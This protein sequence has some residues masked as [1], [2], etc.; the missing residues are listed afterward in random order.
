MRKNM[1]LRLAVVIVAFGFAGNLMAQQAG[2]TDP[3]TGPLGEAPD[4]A[5]NPIVFSVDEGSIGRPNAATTWDAN[6]LVKAGIIPSAHFFMS[7]STG[8]PPAGSHIML[9][10]PWQI[11]LLAN[12]HPS[13]PVTNDDNIDA[14]SLGND[15]FSG[16]G[17]KIGGD[18]LGEDV[19]FSERV[20]YHQNGQ[21]IIQGGNPLTVQF[22]V[23]RV[24]A[25][26]LG[27]AVN[28]NYNSRL[29]P[30][31]SVYQTTWNGYS[32]GTNSELYSPTVLA[33]TEQDDL[34]SMENYVIDDDGSIPDPADCP[35]PHE[36]MFDG[37]HIFFSV[38]RDTRGGVQSAVNVQATLGHAAG[39]IFVSVQPVTGGPSTNL[40]LIS[41]TQLGLSKTG[42]QSL[43][44]D[45]D[46]MV[47]NLLINEADLE[48][49]IRQGLL[50]LEQGV[51]LGMTEPLLDAG[52]ALVMF[53]V[54]EGSIG[55]MNTA[56]D[57]E[58]RI[59]NSEESGDLFFSDLS[60]MNWL[61]LEAT[62]LGLLESDELNALDTTIP[63]PA[64]MLLVGS[65]LLG[66]VGIVRRRRM[67]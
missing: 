43:E 25:G 24:A 63:E 3:H 50:N 52:D 20:N 18:W 38:D 10:T 26:V 14:M 40:L 21:P 51:G 23:N 28:N 33:L 53:S 1:I 49:L 56:V 42:V 61:S 8:T 48:E 66:L 57:Y 60:G 47:L 67:H 37:P 15:Y 32:V 30:A 35:G 41:E 22:S 19:A 54:K 44:D 45:L 46:A 27:S 34:D 2:G 5:D 9:A 17:D 16:G 59:D 62:S 39:D 4:P 55:L 6:D 36:D 64:T 31:G 7:D 29:T 11:G 65:G 13:Y 58:H 12:Y